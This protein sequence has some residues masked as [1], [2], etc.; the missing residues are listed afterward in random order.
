MD[1]SDVGDVVRKQLSSIPGYVCT[2]HLGLFHY[3]ELFIVQQKNKATRSFASWLAAAQ[4]VILYLTSRAGPQ[5]RWCQLTSN[6]AERL[7]TA[8]LAEEYIPILF[9]NPAS[10]P[11]RFTCDLCVPVVGLEDWFVEQVYQNIHGR[12]LA[13]AGPQDIYMPHLGYLNEDK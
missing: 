8:Q 4:M 3:G 12:L 9:S 11:T 10:T 1:R 6:D 2:C 13:P 7:E 5:A